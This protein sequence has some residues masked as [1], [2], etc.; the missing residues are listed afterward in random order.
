MPPSILS[1]LSPPLPSLSLTSRSL[2]FFAACLR[3]PSL[4]LA[5]AI[6][7]AAAVYIIVSC[8]KSPL[9]GGSLS[10]LPLVHLDSCRLALLTLLSATYPPTQFCLNIASLIST[11]CQSLQYHLISSTRTSR[12]V[13]VACII[14]HHGVLQISFSGSHDGLCRRSPGSGV[15]RPGQRTQGHER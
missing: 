13:I 12:S 4:A 11:R 6:P 15:N 8:T 1:F 3:L 10:P 9:S 2:S 5:I 14:S 7:G